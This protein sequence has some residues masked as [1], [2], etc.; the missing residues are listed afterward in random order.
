MDPKQRAR[1]ATVKV[2]VEVKEEEEA[3]YSGRSVASAMLSEQVVLDRNAEAPDSRY[4]AVMTMLDKLTTEGADRAGAQVS[5]HE[6][7]VKAEEA[8][9]EAEAG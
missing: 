4:G 2:T 1:S 5:A 9:A 3:S 6:A 7:L 8:K